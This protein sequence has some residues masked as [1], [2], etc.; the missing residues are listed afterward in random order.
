MEQLS[1]VKNE[2]IKIY[3]PPSQKR[4]PEYSDTD[5][6]KIYTAGK[7]KIG[8]LKKSPVNFLFSEFSYQ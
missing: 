5:E 3:C 8:R 2:V 4:I 1:V 7:K 6:V